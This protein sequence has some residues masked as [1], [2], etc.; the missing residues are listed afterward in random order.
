MFT[1]IVK[2]SL[3]HAPS[4]CSS[5]CRSR[6]QCA[7]ASRAIARAVAQL[8]QPAAAQTQAGEVCEVLRLHRRVDLEQ[9]SRHEAEHLWRKIL[10][11][12]PAAHIRSLK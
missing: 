11:L 7:C 4:K 12:H 6:A 2:S 8:P 5:S 1:G 3:Q 9:V 10:Q